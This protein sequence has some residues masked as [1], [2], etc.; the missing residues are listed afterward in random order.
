MSNASSTST[1]AVSVA[2]VSALLLLAVAGGFCFA[3]FCRLTRF[4]FQ[5]MEGQQLYLGS[6]VAAVVLLFVSRLIGF[7]ASSVSPWFCAPQ[8]SL[9][10]PQIRTVWVDFVGLPGMHGVLAVFGGAFLL[11][12]ALAFLVNRFF[13]SKEAASR[14]ALKK[15]GSELEKF[16]EKSRTETLPVLVTLDNRKVYVGWVTEAPVV[17]PKK[18]GEEYLKLLPKQSGYRDEKNLRLHFTTSF[19]EVYGRISQGEKYKK[20]HDA[21][22]LTAEDFVIVIPVDRIVSLSWHAVDL[23]VPPLTADHFKHST[24]SVTAVGRFCGSRSARRSLE[25]RS[26]SPRRGPGPSPLRAPRGCVPQPP[27]ATP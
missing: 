17:E 8:T 3:Y 24:A 10:M 14:V 26:P 9:C 18:Y 21:K 20:K 7:I 1:A 15:Y 25:C 27:A 23:T 19:E 5:R 6:V 13:V 11:G 12:P 2:T 4:A 22:L 16:A